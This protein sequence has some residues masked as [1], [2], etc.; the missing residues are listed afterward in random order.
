MLAQWGK[1]ENG[2]QRPTSRRHAQ[3]CLMA[4]K[5]GHSMIDFWFYSCRI[6]YVQVLTHPCTSA[7]F[8]AAK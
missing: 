1:V 4:S 6:M 3:S 5:F 8:L 7:V 2:R